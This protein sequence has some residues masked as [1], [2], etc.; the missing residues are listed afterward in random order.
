[1]N[2]TAA[3][4]RAKCTPVQPE[5]GKSYRVI[6]M[7]VPEAIYQVEKVFLELATSKDI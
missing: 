1:M 4:L 3:R 7:S 5:A 2:M 6:G